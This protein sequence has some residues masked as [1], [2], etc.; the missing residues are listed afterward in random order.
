IDGRRQP[1][2]SLVAL[3]SR[4]W[5]AGAARMTEILKIASNVA[6]PLA[7][8]GLIGAL[9]R[10]A[11]SRDLKYLERRP[12]ALPEADRASRVGSLAARY[13]LSA[14]NFTGAQKYEIVLLAMRNEGAVSSYS[15]SRSRSSSCSASSSQPSPTPRTGPRPSRCPP[16]KDFSFTTCQTADD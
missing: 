16:P 3:A 12:Q 8:I 14:A 4:G 10:F 6:T 13:G 2:F 9:A 11:Y 7:V 15:S 5:P 1:R